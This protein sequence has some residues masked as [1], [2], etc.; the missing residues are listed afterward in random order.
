MIDATVERSNGDVR[1]AFGDQSLAVDKAVLTA[2]PAVSS[3]DGRTV[4]LGIRPEHFEDASL[5]TD[6]PPDRR[7]R[8]R[9]ELRE[10]LGSELMV[11]F[12]V[13]GARAADT[14]ET[15][16]I[17]HDVGAGTSGLQASDALF[18][19]RFGARAR[20]VEGEPV[21]VSVDT[22]ALHFFDPETGLGIYDRV[23]EKGAAS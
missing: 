5:A 14:E 10:A 2:R 11:H 17:A 3:Y 4:I 16:E 19:G 15:K 23:Q 12:T 18:V 8:G 20:V 6:T 13:D 7:L 9:V 1:V 22:S 21:E